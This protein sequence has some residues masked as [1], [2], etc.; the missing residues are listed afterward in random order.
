MTVKS[1][2]GIWNHVYGT[3]NFGPYS[4]SC[5]PKDTQAF[6]AWAKRHGFDPSLLGET[7]AVNNRLL[8]KNGKKEGKIIGNRL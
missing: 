5:L 1:C 2:E 7:I 6:Y 3:R 8:K 4:G